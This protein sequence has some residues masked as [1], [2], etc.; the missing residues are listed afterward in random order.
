MKRY[1]L[2]LQNQLKSR[3][4][5]KYNTLAVL[6]FTDAP[7]YKNSGQIAQ[8]LA[9]ILFGQAGFKT[10]ERSKFIN[11]IDE[12]KFSASGLI[13]E[14]ESIKIGKLLG[15]KAV[16]VGEVSQYQTIM[17]RTDTRIASIC[18]FIDDPNLFALGGG[19]CDQ[20]ITVN[21]NSRTIVTRPAA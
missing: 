13:S 15:V 19:S 5:K 4:F 2:E 18:E 16:V 6:P 14:S 17:R 1:T 9:N 20:Q 3:D 7:D 11:I 8:G 10:V 12:Q 21:L